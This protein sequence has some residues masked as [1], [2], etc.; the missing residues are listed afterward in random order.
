[1]LGDVF[2]TAA[3]LPSAGYVIFNNQSE[4]TNE[5]KIV[6]KSKLLS[7]QKMDKKVPKDLRESHVF[8]LCFVHSDLLSS[9]TCS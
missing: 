7:E 4:F 5:P 2:W 1:M 9:K 6:A 8:Y 3:C